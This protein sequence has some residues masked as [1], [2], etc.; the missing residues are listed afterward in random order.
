MCWEVVVFPCEGLV[1]VD[2]VPHTYFFVWRGESVLV[3]NSILSRTKDE[4]LE[5][6]KGLK[7][8]K[9]SGGKVSP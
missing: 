9:E 4:L 6:R 8:E 5:F 7:S 2:V 1:G 3:I